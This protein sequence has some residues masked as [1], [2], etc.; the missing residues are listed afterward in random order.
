VEQH[1]Q[2]Q[3]AARVVEQ[4]AKMTA[5]AIEPMTNTGNPAAA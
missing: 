1:D 4:P 2:Q 3:T 5:P